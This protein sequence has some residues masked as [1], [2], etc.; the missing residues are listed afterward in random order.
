[1]TPWLF[2]L[3]L[4]MRPPGDTHFSVVPVP[5]CD[6]VE[7]C[8]G[9]VRS[10]FY[11]SWVRQ[12]TYEQGKQRYR[13]LVSEQERAIEAIL[14]VR[15]DGT[16]IPDCLPEPIA[17]DK[18]TKKL[19]F[20]PE[21]AVAT[22]LGAAIPE[23]GLRED[24]QVGRGFARPCPKGGPRSIEGVCGPSDDGGMGRGPGG[25]A[26]MMQPHPSIGWRFADGD[27]ALLARARAG[28]KA[29]REAVMQSLVGRDAASVGRCWRTGLR[30]L[31]HA[32]AHCGWSLARG[33]LKEDPWYAMYSQYGT[34][35]SCTSSNHGKTLYRFNVFLKVRAR[36]RALRRVEPWL[37]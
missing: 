5:E 10:T 25:E 6:G 33:K 18:K 29:A 22:M 3:M 7:M 11:R 21:I 36:A 16:Q 15:L 12:E 30:M 28:D 2:A 4:E 23:S 31:L 24:V 17:L 32:Y 20:G 1:M 14:C 35:T 8:E 26:C 27:P 37:G 9:A 19:L 13:M 34:G